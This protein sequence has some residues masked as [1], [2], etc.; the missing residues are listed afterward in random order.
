MMR[1][2]QDYERAIGIV[3]ESLRR[4][5]PYCMIQ[6]G[7]PDDE[8]DPEIGRIVARIRETSSQD[9]I[10]NIISD[11]FN[12]QFSDSYSPKEFTTVATEIYLALVEAG[13]IQSKGHP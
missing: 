10:A 2:R 4:T 12:K 13:L 8:L 7:F 5:D 3:G 9:D 1:T 11:V 6:D